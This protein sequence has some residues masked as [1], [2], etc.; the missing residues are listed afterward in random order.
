[1]REGF[2]LVALF[3]ASSLA[4][5]SVS[6]ASDHG[7]AGQTFPIIEPDLLSTIEGRL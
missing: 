3:V 4:M 5:A 6:R 1:M 7:V 2:E